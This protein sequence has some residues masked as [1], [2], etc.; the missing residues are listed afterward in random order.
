M[1]IKLRVQFEIL[2]KLLGLTNTGKKPKYCDINNKG[3]NVNLIVNNNSVSQKF[4][5][6][7]YFYCRDAYAVIPK[8]D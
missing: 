4:K 3:V 1:L 5:Q 2:C 6:E 7:I 8:R